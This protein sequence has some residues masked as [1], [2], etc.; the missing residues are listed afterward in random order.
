MNHN[1]IFKK[2]KS[3]LSIFI[4]ILFAQDFFGQADTTKKSNVNFWRHFGITPLN[5]TITAEKNGVSFAPLIFYTPDTRW[6]FGLAG[7][8]VFHLKDKSKHSSKHITRASYVR[9]T[10]NYTQNKQSDFWSEWSVFTNREKYFTKGE[11]RL[12]NFPDKFYGIGNNTTKDA[13]EIYS[14][15]LVTF[16]CLGLKQFFPNFFAGIDYHFTKEFNFK[17]DPNGVLSNGN[18]VGYKGGVGSALGLVSI[19]DKRDNV[20]NPHKGQFIELSSYFFRKALGGSFNFTVINAEYRKYFKLKPRHII[21]FQAKS[22]F[23]SG[24]VPFLEMS[25]V[26]NDDLLRGY[27]RHRFR[28]KNL[29]ATQIEYRFPLFWRFGMTTFAGIGDV[30]NNHRDLKLPNVKYTVGTGLRFLMN[31]AERLNIR[32]DYGYGSEGGYFYVSFTEAF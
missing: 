2:L 26:G 12:R 19:F 30:F 5:D 22:R 20:M 10:T 3:I 16:K 13:Y 28:D 8:Y 4:L 18:I 29:L 17:L 27:P 24:N 11:I 21:A 14:Y 32:V 15:N 25:Q 9:F 23:S 31:T 6:A 1:A 7:A